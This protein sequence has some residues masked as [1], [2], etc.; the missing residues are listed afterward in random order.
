MPGQQPPRIEARSKHSTAIRSGLSERARAWEVVHASQDPAAATELMDAQ[1]A[2]G[3]HPYAT[4]ETGVLL[5]GA[6]AER[7]SQHSLIDSWKDVRKWRRQLD[8]CDAQIVHAHCFPAAMAS[9]RSNRPTVYDLRAF[10]EDHAIT[11]GQ[12]GERSWMARSFRTAEQFA[13]GRASAVV[14]HSQAMRHA[15]R[16]RGVEEDDIFVVPDPLF[17]ETIQPQFASH[18]LEQ[19]FGFSGDAIAIYADLGPISSP[20]ETIQMRA[21]LLQAFSQVRGEVEA[22]RLFVTA[23]DDEHGEDDV[24]AIAHGLE[25]EDSV[26]VLASADAERAIGSAHIVVAGS[27]NSL[28]S[29]QDRVSSLEVNFLALQAMLHQ[30]CLLAADAP[31][32]RDISRDGR[33]SL[34]YQYGDAR[35]LAHRLAFLARNEDFR[36]ALAESGHRHLL[37]SRNPEHVGKIY[38]QVYRHAFTNGNRDPQQPGSAISVLM[39]KAIPS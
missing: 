17:L 34:W 33:G 36:R 39:P 27:E 38:D 12:C 25:I 14:V 32:N 30:R 29:P 19:A 11:C 16:H 2:V 15:C 10:V 24:R 23:G 31:S 21:T 8:S 28:R 35:D 26:F 37:Q 22:A 4:T 9:V 6:V 20:A 7:A 3:M 1:R 5:P 18:W 13:L